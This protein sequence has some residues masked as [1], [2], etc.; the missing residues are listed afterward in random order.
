MNERCYARTEFFDVNV[1]EQTG[2]DRGVLRGCSVIDV[3]FN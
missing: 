2:F 3:R 1:L